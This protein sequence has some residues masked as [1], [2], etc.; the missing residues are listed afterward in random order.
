MPFYLKADLQCPEIIAEGGPNGLAAIYKR[1]NLPERLSG[2]AR[3][4]AANAK[5][6]KKSTKEKGDISRV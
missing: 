6:K 5:E 3:N 4:M 1:A 2:N